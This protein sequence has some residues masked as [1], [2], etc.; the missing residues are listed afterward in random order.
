MKK[1]VSKEVIIQ[2]ASKIFVE[3][4]AKTTVD[5]LSRNMKISKRTIYE[6]FEDKTDLLRECLVFLVKTLPE[7]PDVQEN[8][9]NQIPNIIQIVY[10]ITIPLFGKKSRFITEIY[11]Q[12]PDLF[13]EQLSPYIALLQKKM[14]ENFTLCA[15]G[16]YVRPDITLEL[17]M[18][19]LLRVMYTVTFRT[20]GL[21]AKFSHRTIY[22][23]IILPYL[24]GLFTE[25]GIKFFDENV[26]KHL[27]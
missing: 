11:Q 4:G 3:Q 16:G 17:V 2:K 23:S 1:S 20:D 5:E 26:K 22:M 10:D 21:L 9:D 7:F 6:Q 14:M 18:V 12:Y 15:K 8:T 25:K 19:C 13:T 27:Q 24:R